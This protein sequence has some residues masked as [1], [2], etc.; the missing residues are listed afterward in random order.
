[1]YPYSYTS[2]KIIHDEQIEEVMEQHRLYEGED[3]RKQGLLQKFGKLLARFTAQPEQGCEKLLPD[4]VP[5]APCVG[6]PR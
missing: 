2:M 3:S 5:S 1:M 4:C 6:E